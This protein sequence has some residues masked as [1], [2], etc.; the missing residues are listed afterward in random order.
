[1]MSPAQL[2]REEFHLPIAEAVLYRLDFDPPQPFVAALGQKTGQSLSAIRGLTARSY[3]PR[4]LDTLESV[5]YGAQCY[6]HNLEFLMPLCRRRPLRRPVVPWYS[7]L[8]F[9]SPRGCR[10]CMS[11]QQEPYLRLRWRFSWMVT[12]PLHRLV[13]KP[14]RIVRSESGPTQVMWS[15][16]QDTRVIPPTL[17]ALE[18]ATL[19]AITRH[20]CK[21]PCGTIA[22]GF[23]LR[24]LRTILEELC[25]GHRDAGKDR[26]AIA[27]LWSDIGLSYRFDLQHRKYYESM[28]QH[29]KEVFMYVASRAIAHVFDRDPAG[30][31]IMDMAYACSNARDD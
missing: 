14:C 30:A 17:L 7:T 3:M 10:H 20:S 23:W 11:E 18:A 9:R 8:H 28:S 13:L 4:L 1:M 5:S 26:R 27:K 15:D 29:E 25:I 19:Q 6:T 12:C 21:L 31:R 2:L 24:L 16:Q 22:G